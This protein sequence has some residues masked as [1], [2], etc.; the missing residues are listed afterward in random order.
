MFAR[1]CSLGMKSFALQGSRVLVTGASS[2]IGEQLARVFAEQ[3]SHLVLVARSGERLE[4]L[5]AELRR[6]HGIEIVCCSLDLMEPGAPSRLW[7]QLKEGGL[8]ID[9]LVNN[10]GLGRAR[11]FAEDELEAPLQV[12]D[13]NCRVLTE[14]THLFLPSLITR[15]RGGILLVA[16]LVSFFPVPQMAVYAASKAYVRSFGEALRAELRGTGV[17]V[18][19]LC[20]GNVQ[21]GFQRAAGF[22]EGAVATPGE[23]SAEETARQAVRGFVQ[24]RG[25]VI[26]GR[27]NRAA[28]FLAHWIP[29][30]GIARVAAFVLG[31]SGRFGAAG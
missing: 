15:R 18:T 29:N 16:S 22:A 14:L 19:V 20:P 1:V 3:G 25:R 13:L 5:A 2:G 4:Q 30:V 27:I 17:H 12:L 8:E 26:P 31:R 10:A 11:T 9:V 28:A 24:R 7:T 6:A 21:T 23:L